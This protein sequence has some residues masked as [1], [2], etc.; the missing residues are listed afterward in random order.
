MKS[1]YAIAFIITIAILGVCAEQTE[2]S[3]KAI[4]AAVKSVLV[5]AAFT[6]LG[7]LFV[8]LS[9]NESLSLLSY[10][11]FFVG[12]DWLLYSLLHFSVVYTGTAEKYRKCRWPIRIILLMDSASMVLN[13]VF[14]HAFQCKLVLTETGE[15]FY[16]ITSY[17]PYDV[18]L[19]ISYLLI[20]ASFSC[21]IHKALLTPVLY[22]AKY[23]VL[24]AVLTAVIIGD[25]VY[26]FFGGVIDASILLFAAAGVLLYYFAMIYVPKGLVNKI[27]MVIVQNLSDGIVFFDMDGNCAFINEGAKEIYKLDY[28]YGVD[29]EEEFAL[30]RKKIEVFDKEEFVC[31]HKEVRNGHEWQLRIRFRRIKD[32]RGCY[33]G[34]LLVMTDRTEEIK[35]LEREHYLATHDVLTGLYNKEYFFEQVE[36]CLREHPDGEYLMLCSDV[37]DFKLINDVFGKEAGDDLLERI[38]KDIRERIFPGEIYGRLENDRFGIFVQKK[39]YSEMLVSKSPVDLSHVKGDISYPVSIHLGIYE[40]RDKEIP[41]SGMCDRAF[42]A[43]GTIKGN[44]QKKIAYYDDTLREIAL[45]EKELSGELGEALETGQIQIYLQPQVTAEGT[46]GGAEALVRWIHPQKGLIMPGEF[47]AV[48]EKN[49][50]IAQLDRHVWKLACECLKKW[51]KEGK[52]HCY[53]SVNISPKDFYFMDVYQTITDLVKQYDIEPRNLKLEIT[54]TAVMMN[55][56]QQLE[57]IEKLQNAGFIVEMDDFGS[58]YSSLN[59]LKDIRVDEL[60]V[61]MAFLRKTKDEERSKKILRIIVELS[62]QLDMPVIIEGVETAEQVAFL[63]EIGC[64]IF[65][66]YFFARPVAVSQFEEMY[67]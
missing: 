28:D 65:Q 12:I 6:V 26:V 2:K 33:L 42:M 64:D 59:M 16:R 3:S 1:G 9:E 51:K 43:I 10:S 20:L 34:T 29:P 22:R 49:G 37:K 38:G 46:V 55:L 19:L 36:K 15:N 63:K 48:F 66:G 4:A 61:D 17:R 5:W 54:E 23:L 52:S 58:G 13:M 45:R 53:I 40:I 67:L 7:N 24:V 35:G 14:Q 39:N 31:D 32:K 8:V 27:Q 18:H 62:K 25:A 57:I 47:I 30:W 50:M 60:K 56:E 11:M 44:I 21:M 41:V